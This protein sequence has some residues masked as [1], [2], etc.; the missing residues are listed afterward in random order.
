MQGEQHQHEIRN[1]SYENGTRIK[2][3]G[4]SHH[5][6]DIG[7]RQTLREETI[8]LTKIDDTSQ[9]I[10]SIGYQQVAERSR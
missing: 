10:G 1:I 6:H 2:H 4:T 7:K 9:E 3:Q 5:L 8:I